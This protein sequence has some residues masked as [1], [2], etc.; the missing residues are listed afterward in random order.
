VSRSPLFHVLLASLL[1]LSV[2]GCDSTSSPE[3]P[4][5][6]PHDF[7]LT[8]EIG[9]ETIRDGGDRDADPE[10]NRLVIRNL[11]PDAYDGELLV[12]DLLIEARIPP[13]GAGE[14][15]TLATTV[16]APEEDDE[17][18]AQLAMGS[19]GATPF[20]EVELTVTAS[21]D[22]YFSG[23][24]TGYEST[25]H[26]LG[27]YLAVNDDGTPLDAGTISYAYA[28]F[29]GEVERREEGSAGA[30]LVDLG[31]VEGEEIQDE[32]SP[33]AFE[34]PD[35]HDELSPGDL[36]TGRGELLLRLGPGSGGS[37]PVSAELTLRALRN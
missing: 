6:E 33:V 17:E 36:T 25:V 31:S 23:E 20:T 21:L 3:E 15:V 34:P 7:Q 32:E 9:G 11:R 27:D 24:P 35:L 8:M 29:A 4:D 19:G 28:R 22:G 13:G 5:R 2:S 1:A 26:L 10:P 30:R 18:S 16:P 14:A 37:L 12:D